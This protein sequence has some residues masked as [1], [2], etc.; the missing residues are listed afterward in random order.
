MRNLILI[1]AFL[2]MIVVPCYAQERNELPMYGGISPTPEQ[3]K[4]DREFIEAVVKD[5]GSREAA[6]KTAIRLGFQY[7]ARNDWRIAMKRFNQAW[8]LTGEGMEVFW[9]FA[10]ALSY[11]GKFEESEKYFQKALVLAPNNGRLIND[12]GF[13]YQFWATKGTKAKDE[14]LK[15]LDKSVQLF[16]QA[17]R[18]EPNYERIYFNWAVSLYFKGDY[19]GAWDKVKEAERLGG[20]T[21]EPKFLQDLSK[22]M[23]RP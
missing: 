11:Q 13:M 9:G 3:A 16:E 10:S 8:L 12:Y 20:K 22:K 15:R 7:L 17:N 21:V 18:L 2:A 14:K 5:Q 6:S 4:A 23:P 19:R 1:A